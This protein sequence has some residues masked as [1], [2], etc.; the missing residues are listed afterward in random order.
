M[1]SAGRGPLAADRVEPAADA[2][3][4]PEAPPTPIRVYTPAELVALSAELRAAYRALPAFGAATRLRPEEWG[5]LERRHIERKQRIVRVEQK[6]IGAGSC[7]VA[8]PTK[9]VREVP[10]TRAALDMI[11]A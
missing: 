5:V 3:L 9:S 1:V 11:P 7:S 8:R 2:G 10:L 4:N 6:N